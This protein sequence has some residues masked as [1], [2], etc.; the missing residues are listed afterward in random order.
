P[1]TE[2]LL[3]AVERVNARKTYILPNNKNVILAAE[4]A[5]KLT[6][7]D[8]AVIPSKSIQQGLSALFEFDELG[9]MEDNVKQMT[10][11][12][13]DVKAGSITYAT[14]DTVIDSVNIKKGEYIGLANG[15]IKVSDESRLTVAKDLLDS[16]IDEN[17]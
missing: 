11:V 2:D 10:A 7:K 12:L 9:S 13:D 16:I 17:L 5:T 15:E 1:S 4:Q 14:R 8:V 6:E 3:Q